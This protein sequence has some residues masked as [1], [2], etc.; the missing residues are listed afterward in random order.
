MNILALSVIV[1]DSEMSCSH[2]R[3]AVASAFG[4]KRKTSQMEPSICPS[5]RQQT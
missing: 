1:M 2:A 5:Q 4:K 3:G